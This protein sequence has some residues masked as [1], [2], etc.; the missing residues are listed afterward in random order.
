VTTML[1]LILGAAVALSLA[2]YLVA[3]LVSPEKF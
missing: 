3:T 2:A 1:D